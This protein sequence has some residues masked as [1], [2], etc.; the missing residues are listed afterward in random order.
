[1]MNMTFNAL[2]VSNFLINV[3]TETGNSIFVFVTFIFSWIIPANAIVI[4]ASLRPAAYERSQSILR[5][6]HMTDMKYQV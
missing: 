2:Y 4:S 5:R 1:M 6:I 3:S